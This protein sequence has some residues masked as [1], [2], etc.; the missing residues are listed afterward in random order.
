MVE[1]KNAMIELLIFYAL[2]W[3]FMAHA[4]KPGLLPTNVY[5]QCACSFV[6]KKIKKKNNARATA[7]RLLK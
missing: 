1:E 4:P 7:T 5:K 6:V 2:G 3:L